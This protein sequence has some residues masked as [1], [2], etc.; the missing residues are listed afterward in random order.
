MPSQLYAVSAMD[1]LV[2]GSVGA[3][4]AVVAFVACTLPARR[5]ARIEAVIALNQN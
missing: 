4:L 2:L 3:V 5:A 1:P